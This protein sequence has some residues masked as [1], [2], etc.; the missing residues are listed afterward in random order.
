MLNCCNVA[1][2][3]PWGSGHLFNKE[4]PGLKISAGPETK[5]ILELVTV[6]TSLSLLLLHSCFLLIIEVKQHPTWLPNSF[7][8][9]IPCSI[10]HMYIFL[11]PKSS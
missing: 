3:F 4:V 1:L 8:P 6:V 2:P 5:E 11:Q 7:G 10:N 9:E